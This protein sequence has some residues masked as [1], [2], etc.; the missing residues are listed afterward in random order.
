LLLK[1]AEMARLL[2]RKNSNGMRNKK[3]YEKLKDRLE[4]PK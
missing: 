2:A 4:T 3:R 1:E